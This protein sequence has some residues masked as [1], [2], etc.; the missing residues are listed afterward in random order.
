MYKFA[1]LM[2]LVAVL[3]ASSGCSLSTSSGSVTVQD[4]QKYMPILESATQGLTMQAL[5]SQTANV[6]Q[7]VNQVAV[8]M[9]AVVDGDMS[10]SQ[11]DIE[12]LLNIAIVK[13]Q[14]TLT[15]ASPVKPLLRSMLMMAIQTAEDRVNEWG[16]TASKNELTIEFVKA[17]LNGVVSGSKM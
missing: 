3:L 15:D 1:V 2:S 10:L 14:L 17:A 7:A 13:S 16:L 4:V 9:L 8:Q 6:K 11:D 5:K 12:N